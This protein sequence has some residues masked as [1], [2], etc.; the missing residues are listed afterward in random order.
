MKYLVIFLISLQAFSQATYELNA[1]AVVRNKNFKAKETKVVLTHLF[2]KDSFDGKYFKI[3]KGKEEIA[4]STSAEEG[5]LLKAST[6]YYH[7]NK[8]RLFFA[9]KL[10]SEHV[11][12]LGKLT[13]RIDLINKYNDLGHFA[14]ENMSPQFNN[15][16][17]IPGGVGFP[18]RGIEPWDTEI[19]FRPK[20]KV[21]IK[22]IDVKDDSIKAYS[23][24]LRSFRQQT[25]M[26]SFQRFLV[27]ALHPDSEGIF[28]GGVTF[29][30]VFRLVGSSI[31]MEASYQGFDLLNRV[32]RRKN[33]WLESALVP[34]IIYHEYSHVALSD[35]LKLSHSTP[36]NEGLADYF[37]ATIANS[38][39]LATRIKKYNTFSGKKAK[40]KKIYQLQFETTQYA[41]TDFVFGLLW[42]LKKILGSKVAN[43]FVYRLRELVSTNSSIKKQLIQGILDT[44]RELC[45][46]PST[47]RI[48]LLKMLNTKGM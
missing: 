18:S 11:N 14:H 48:K 39:K 17:S 9:N 30:S 24:I 8:A 46:A 40:N 31:I 36:V 45:K 41:N 20:K 19:W 23:G 32:F 27:A 26:Q 16:L 44:C 34:E 21:N 35:F 4:I 12:T 6:V 29:N 47:D 42:E 37:A 28:P 38:S 25:H 10:G 43:N 2:S 7:L 15:A 13:I 22:D 5:L 1:I 3:V 33:Y